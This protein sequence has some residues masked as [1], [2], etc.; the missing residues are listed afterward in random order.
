MYKIYVWLNNRD[1]SYYYKVTKGTYKNYQIGDYNSYNHKLVLIIPLDYFID[2]RKHY[3]VSYKKML[4]NDTIRFLEK[5][6]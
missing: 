1:K 3:Y 2:Q 4:I 5:Y 6:R